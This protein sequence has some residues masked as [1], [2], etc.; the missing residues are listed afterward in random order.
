MTQVVSV[1]KIAMV[2]TGLSIR[3]QYGIR[4]NTCPGTLAETGLCK[5]GGGEFYSINS[6]ILIPMQ[7][8]PSGAR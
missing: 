1:L 3:K 4:Q 5:R 8:N 6:A 7:V 2:F